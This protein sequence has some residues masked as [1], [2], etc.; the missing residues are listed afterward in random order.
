[1]LG[2]LDYISTTIRQPPDT[3]PFNEKCPQLTCLILIIQYNFVFPVFPVDVPSLFPDSGNQINKFPVFS[4]STIGVVFWV[5]SI[6][7]L[8]DR[9]Q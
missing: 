7:F 4:V 3:S 8:T 9:E 6:S 2:T 1:M 5:C